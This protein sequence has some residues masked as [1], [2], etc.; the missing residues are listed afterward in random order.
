MNNRCLTTILSVLLAVPAWE[1]PA[2]CGGGDALAQT[3]DREGRLV[4]GTVTSNDG[5]PLVGAFVYVKNSKLGVNT[6]LDGHYEIAAPAEGAGFK[7]LVQHNPYLLF[8]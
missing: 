2:V 1:T 6:D 4:K 8:C 7:L 5:E 3:Q